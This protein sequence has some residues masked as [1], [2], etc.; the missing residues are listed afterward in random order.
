MHFKEILFEVKNME[1]QNWT[2]LNVFEDKN[3]PNS[4]L[5]EICPIDGNNNVGN[6]DALEVPKEETDFWLSCVG[7]E[8]DYNKGYSKDANP[9]IDIEKLKRILECRTPEKVMLN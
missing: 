5:V 7:K 9:Q 8:F 2:I 4:L 3:F 6:T 1:K